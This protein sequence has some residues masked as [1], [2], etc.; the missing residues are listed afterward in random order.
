MAKKMDKLNAN[1]LVPARTRAEWEAQGW[2]SQ[3][4]TVTVAP[5]L[6]A[7]LSIRFDPDAALLL[8]H[9]ARLKGMTKSEFVRHAAVQEARKTIEESLSTS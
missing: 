3:S 8:R 4:E 9:A 6:E 2:A 5:R 7:T 1:P